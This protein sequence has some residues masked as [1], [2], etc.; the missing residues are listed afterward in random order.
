MS[1][2]D[3]KSV[4]TKK[5][6]N[7]NWNEKEM[8]DPLSLLDQFRR[9]RASTLFPVYGQNPGC[10]INFLFLF[11]VIVAMKGEVCESVRIFLST[12]VGSW[13]HPGVE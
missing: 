7:Y 1:G 10:C 6:W 12:P 11:I 8:F 4:S 3:G 5:Y 13:P 9:T 2:A